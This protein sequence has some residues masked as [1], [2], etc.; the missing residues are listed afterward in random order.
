VAPSD[1]VVL[2]VRAWKKWGTVQRELNVN[3]D[4]ISLVPCGTSGGGGSV[5]C[6]IYVVKPGDTLSKIAKKYGTTTAVLARMNGIKNPNKIYVGQKLKV[7]CAVPQPLPVVVPPADP[8]VVIVD[9]AKP[10]VVIV[11]PAKPPVVVVDPAKPV[12]VVP[13]Q[14]A[15]DDQCV[16]VV[17]KGGD[18][19]GKI[20][21][22]NGSTVAIIVS[23]NQIKN[24]NIIMVGQ[25]L[26][27]PK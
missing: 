18:T 12:V 26:C 13:P 19:L 27:I 7:P 14:P 20:A 10:P 17:V 9:P 2:A 25:K 1:K 15:P 3:L 21:K 23:K 22:A 8:P 24:A 6:C 16:W 5:E 11:D 4:T